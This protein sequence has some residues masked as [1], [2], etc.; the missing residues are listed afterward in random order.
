MSGIARA[1]EAQDLKDFVDKYPPEIQAAIAKPASR[2]NPY[3]MADVLQ[4]EAVSR[5]RR[6]SGRAKRSRAKTRRSTQRCQ[7]ELSEIRRHRS[8]RPAGGIGMRDVSAKAPATHILDVG[9]WDAPEEEVQPGFLTFLI[10]VPAKISPGTATTGRRT[11]LANWLT[12]PANPLTARVMV[13]RLWHYHFGQGIVATPSDFGVMGATPTTSRVARLARQRIRAQRL[14]HEAHAQ[15]D[16]DVRNLS[17][18]LRIST[19]S[20]QSRSAQ[21]AALAV[22]ARSASKAKSFAIPRL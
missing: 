16:R 13:N 10:P 5:N 20:P 21:Q 12:D 15:A 4:G 14:G 18:V 1:R 17:S 22:P 11:A 6:R 19:R 9:V 7:A 8:R 3:R 2:R